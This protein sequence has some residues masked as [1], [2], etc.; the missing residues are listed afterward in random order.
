MRSLAFLVYFGLLFPFFCG[1][2]HTG[3]IFFPWGGQFA[4]G[5]GS[6]IGEKMANQLALKKKMG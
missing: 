4:K 3:T 6:V 1:P 2:A 5:Y